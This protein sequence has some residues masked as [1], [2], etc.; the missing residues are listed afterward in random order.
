MFFFLSPT[1][2]H[3]LS[4][5]RS[6]ALVFGEMDHCAVRDGTNTKLYRNEKS[7]GPINKY[8][9]VSWAAKWKSGTIPGRPNSSPDLNEK[10]RK[11]AGPRGPSDKRFHTG[12]PV[13]RHAIVLT[14]SAVGSPSQTLATKTRLLKA[15]PPTGLVATAASLEPPLSPSPSSLTQVFEVSIHAAPHCPHRCPLRAVTWD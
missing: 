14:V 8:F 3:I 9:R 12:P 13:I 1:N 2:Y 6:T 5:N 15:R 11:S 7:S 10:A 4:D